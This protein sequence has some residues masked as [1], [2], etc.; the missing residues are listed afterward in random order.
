MVVAGMRR[1]QQVLVAVLDPAHRE[2]EFE[3]QRGEDDLLRIEPRLRAEPA[4][5][6]GRDDAQ[7]A[8]R[9]AEDFADRDAHR[10]RRLGRGIDHDLVEPVIAVRKHRRG[11]PSASPTAGSCGIRG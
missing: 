4:A 2:V 7:L 10:M 5:D 6:I 9:H 1:G 3:G 11:P 8:Q